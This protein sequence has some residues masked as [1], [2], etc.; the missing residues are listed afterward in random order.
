[1]RIV[2]A[3]AGEVV[4]DAPDRRVEILSDHPRVHATWSRFGP[5]RRGAQLHVHHE[6]TDFFFVLSGELTVRLG[7]EGRPNVV[8]PGA[9][10]RV[11]PRV[12][13]GFANEAAREVRYLNFHIP[14]KGF[15]DFMRGLLTA[16]D[17]EYDQ[18]DP[19]ADGG[20]PAR[21]ASVADPADPFRLETLE[22]GSEISRGG[23]FALY[24]LD[25]ELAAS[26]GT[27][28]RVITPGAWVQPSEGS[29]APSVR[30]RAEAKALALRL[31]ED[32]GAL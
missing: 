2:D 22:T 8:R 31:R 28:E 1:M 27:A 6:H 16:D 11:P 29:Q 21:E 19:P 17:P 10:V 9:L 12:V 23:L 14:G 32:A 20:R 4:G 13:H 3:G 24:L 5:H 18:F 15:A 7:P 26:D 25:G 30:V